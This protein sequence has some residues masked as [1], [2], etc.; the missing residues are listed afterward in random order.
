M[1]LVFILSLSVS[2]FASNLNNNDVTL[3]DEQTEEY[4]ERMLELKKEQLDVRVEYGI[5]TQEEADEILADMELRQEDC[6]GIGTGFGC[7]SGNI[8]QGRMGR[9]C[10]GR[11]GCGF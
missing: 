3:T 8:G 9:R 1:V 4:Q 2:V 10:Q 11:V 6:T 7:G 5:I